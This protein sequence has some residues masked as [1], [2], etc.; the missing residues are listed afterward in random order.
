MTLLAKFKDGISLLQ[1]NCIGYFIDDNQCT[2]TIYID[3]KEYLK[4]DLYKIE[5]IFIDNN[6][7]YQKEW[8]G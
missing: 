6:I 3:S 4:F 5:K 2:I 1:I 7:V 8:L